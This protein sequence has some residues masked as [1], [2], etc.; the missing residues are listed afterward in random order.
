MVIKRIVSVMVVWLCM[1]SSSCF[2]IADEQFLNEMRRFKD[3]LLEQSSLKD[4]GRIY[5]RGTIRH[6][7]FA[8]SNLKLYKEGKSLLVYLEN[9]RRLYEG[10]SFKDWKNATAELMSLAEWNSSRVAWGNLVINFYI[11]D[12]VARSIYLRSKDIPPKSDELKGVSE[13]Y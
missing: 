2:S 7:Y 12:I 6:N 1:Y 10:L 11:A 13:H 9:N 5:S 8:F 3:R 4:G